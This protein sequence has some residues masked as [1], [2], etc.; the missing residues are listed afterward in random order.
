MSN[1]GVQGGLA[2]EHEALMQFVY[3]APV[4]LVEM[5]G[6]GDILMINPI[7]AQLL[8][9]LQPDGNL[10]NLFDALAG[11]AP[12]LRHLCMMFTPSSGMVCDGLRIHLNAGGMRPRRGPQVLSLSLVRLDATRLMAVL[13]DVTEQVQ[14]E[15]QLRQNDAW[16]N[17]LLTSI[18][19]YALIGLDDAGRI[20][21]WNE[22][23]GRVT[24]HGKEVVGQPYSIF[25]PPDSITP[26]QV[27]DRLSEADQNG[28]NLDEGPRLRAD[29]S[30]FWASAM[31]SPLPDRDALLAEPDEPAYCMVVRD[32]SDK[33]DAIEMRRKSVFTD[34]LTGVGNRRAFFEAAE[35]ELTRN[36]RAPR[37]TALIVID[38]DHFKHVNDR[39]GHPGGDAVL[40]QLGQLLSTT[41]RQVDVVAR[42][43][44]EEFAVLLPSTGLEGALVVA[45]RLRQLVAQ[46]AVAFEG[47]DIAYTISAGVVASLDDTL[48]LDTMMKRAD[49]ALYAAKA[50]GRDR[51]QAWS[52]ALDTTTGAVALRAAH[53]QQ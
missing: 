4:G 45:E 36:R 27:H 40:R 7:S 32:I 30:R 52:A 42:I 39:H 48:H 5:D 2:A 19:D 11:V 21:E 46:Q 14:R 50:G 15:R 44:G 1:E 53:G 47:A 28:W 38:A 49:Q 51:V 33:R 3:L 25:Y 16:L 34:H 13:S 22:T 8:M 41:F 17:A 6:N 12:E 26:E 10:V 43:G 31:I 24:G 9:P 29:G 37:P 18:T 23:V 20:C 35:L